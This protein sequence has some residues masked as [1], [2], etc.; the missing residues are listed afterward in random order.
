MNNEV[1]HVRCPTMLLMDLVQ[2]AL[3]TRGQNFPLVS[4]GHTNSSKPGM[5]SSSS[6]IPRGTFGKVLIFKSVGE[7]LLA[8]PGHKS[9]ILLNI[10]QCTGQS[11]T[12]NNYLT[13]N[14]KD[15]EV[16]KPSSN[17]NNSFYH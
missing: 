1:L 10:L 13:Q 16:K 4:M 3:F 14:V 17:G 9:K 5:L 2:R 6:R 8:S 7:V 12:A 11:V 15:A